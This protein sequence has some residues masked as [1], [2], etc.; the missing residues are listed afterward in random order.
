MEEKRDAEF[1]TALRQGSALLHEGKAQEAVPFLERA[2]QIK[3]TDIDVGINLGG[4]YILT[5]K[6]KKAARILEPLSEREPNEAMVWVN[7]GAAYLGN[8]VLATDA[9]QQQALAAFKRALELNP[10]A[11]S[12]AYNI[13]LIYRDRQ[14]T[15][16]A[17]HWFRQAVAHNPQDRDARRI[18]QRLTSEQTTEE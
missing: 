7:L 8:P 17:I 5:Q 3:P 1:A 4:A 13:G 18:L 9:Q 14:E 16:E 15:A 10:A 6:F 12:V 11:P 2:H